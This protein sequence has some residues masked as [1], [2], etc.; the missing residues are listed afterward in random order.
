[1]RYRLFFGSFDIKAKNREEAI[2]QYYSDG[3]EPPISK[4]LLIDKAGF[5]IEN[6]KHNPRKKKRAVMDYDQG[7]E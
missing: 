7:I 5:V 6:K 4:I 3:V 2:T 1:M